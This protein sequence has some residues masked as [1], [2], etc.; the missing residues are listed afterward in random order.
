MN[1]IFE[2]I[3]KSS[4]ARKSLSKSMCRKTGDAFLIVTTHCCARGDETSVHFAALADV[5]QQQSI[6]GS[7]LGVAIFFSLPFLMKIFFISFA[8]RFTLQLT[9]LFT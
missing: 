7:Q 3:K 9:I 6:G 4:C 8:L 1:E 2:D 5:Q